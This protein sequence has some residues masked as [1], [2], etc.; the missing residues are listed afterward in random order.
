MLLYEAPA[1]IACA[2]FERLLNSNSFA[3]GISLILYL[4]LVLIMPFGH[5]YL[6]SFLFLLRGLCL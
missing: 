5:S 4:L 6:P 3:C 1:A 2:V